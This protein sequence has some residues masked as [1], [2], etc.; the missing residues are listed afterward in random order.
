[1]IRNFIFC[2]AL[3]LGAFSYA[4][5]PA[6]TLDAIPTPETCYDNGVIDVTVDGT[7]AGVTVDYVIY[8]MPDTGTPVG[9]ALGNAALPGYPFSFTGLDAGDYLVVATQTLGV[10]T[11]TEQLIVIV[12]DLTDPVTSE[13]TFITHYILCGNDGEIT[14]DVQQGTAASFQLSMQQPDGTFQIVAPAQDSNVFSGLTGGVYVIGILDELCGNLIN[15]THTIPYEPLGSVEFLGSEMIP[16]FGDDCDANFVLVRQGLQVP[17]KAFPITVTFTVYPPDG[18]DPVILEQE[19]PF[20]GGTDPLQMLINQLIPYYPG[21][22]YYDIHVTN[23]CGDSWSFGLNDQPVFFELEATAIISPSICYG[24]DISV[25]NFTSPFTV[26]FI[27]HPPLFAPPTVYQI[28]PDHIDFGVEHP[29]PFY[30]RDPMTG[31]GTVTYGIYPL[32]EDDGTGEEVPVLSGQYVI[33]VT[34]ACG[35]EGI[36]EL[37]IPEEIPDPNIFTVARAPHPDPTDAFLDCVGVGDVFLQHQINLAE[38]Y[39]VDAPDDYKYFLNNYNFDAVLEK[40]VYLG[41]GLGMHPDLSEVNPLDVSGW[42]GQGNPPPTVLAYPSPP[43]PGGIRPIYPGLVGLGTYYLKAID[44]CGNE[45]YLDEELKSFI[46]LDNP[47][48]LDPAPACDGKASIRISPLLDDTAGPIVSAVVLGAPDDFYSEFGEDAAEHGNIDVRVVDEEGNF[49]LD[50]EGNFI[51]DLIWFAHHIPNIDPSLPGNWHLT[52]SALPP[53]TYEVNV[54]ISCVD[55]PI[56]FTVDPHIHDTSVDLVEGCGVFDFQFN[57]TAN[58]STNWPWG[59]SYTLELHDEDTDTWVP[60]QT[61]LVPGQM[62]YNVNLQ[63]DFRIVKNYMAWAQG[64][65]GFSFCTEVIYEFEFTGD[66]GIKTVT[67]FSCPEGGSEVIIEATGAAPLTYWVFLNGAW[68]SNG[69]SNIFTNLAPGTYDFMVSDNCGSQTPPATRQIGEPINF[70]VV[71]NNLCDEQLGTLSVQNYSFFSYEWYKID[72]NGAEVLVGTGNQ[73]VFDPF[74]VDTD[75]GI[76]IVKIIYVNNP[77]SCLNQ[78]IEYEVGVSLPNAGDDVTVNFCHT[79]QVIELFDLF[80]SEYDA[81]GTWEDVDNSGALNG[82]VFDTDGVALGTYI[83]RYEVSTACYGSDDAYITITLLD[84]PTAPQVDPFDAVCPGEDLELSITGANPQYTYT[85]T[86]P[87]GNT[88]TG[89]TV[90]LTDVST[91]DTGTY[92]VIA[93]LGTCVS[94]PT[95]VSVVVKPLADFTIA[96]STEICTTLT[97]VGSNFSAQDATYSWT[98]GGNEVGTGESLVTDEEGEYLVTVTLDGCATTQSVNVTTPEIGVEFGCMDNQFMLFVTNTGDFSN[99]TYEW[100]GPGFSNSG[101]SVNISGLET[102]DYTIT[103]TDTEGCTVSN[104][105]TITGTQCMIPKGVSPNGDG[106]N[107]TFDLSNFNVSE[108]KIFNRYGR[109]VFEKENGYTNEWYGQTTDNDDLLPSATYYYL[110]TFMDG[111][112]KSGWVYLNRDE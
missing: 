96:S 76:Y 11:S 33:K 63:G 24:I 64:G 46:N 86:L 26:E 39:I 38:V 36:V 81:G 105:V 80:T 20:P 59:L 74:D 56:T 54:K 111:V 3:L 41:E 40:F 106:N 22:Y 102:G 31:I 100:T 25:N 99:V 104:V 5:L 42:I 49:V 4:Q 108:V 17:A 16:L 10:E 47:F 15:M 82:S 8:K 18:S 37:F 109:T 89:A 72:D 85:W 30:H 55:G 7:V 62:T 44:I 52:L 112:Q 77:D 91:Q 28:D 58:H 60:V 71:E 79:N 53:G 29:G 68:V 69:E 66:P 48:T 14:V 34:D 27:E 92:T 9:T 107:D 2:F 87:N 95:T 19:I 21:E 61:G 23:V 101:D 6:F 88:Y 70:S 110:V 12:E 83:F 65:G 98:Y 45:Y 57:H 43:P 94:D 93:T 1:M 97:V 90:P 67:S 51:Y 78:E 32:V 103:I 73:L 50:E 75:G 84:M 35:V 13:T